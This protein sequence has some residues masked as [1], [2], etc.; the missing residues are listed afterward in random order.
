MHP[1]GVLRQRGEGR[2]R[3]HGK[4][5]R[6]QRQ[7]SRRAGLMAGRRAGWRP[8]CMV[9]SRKLMAAGPDGL[10]ASGAG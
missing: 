1:L 5:A 4:A 6:R 10:L 8:T 7:A 3:R 9:V 2:R